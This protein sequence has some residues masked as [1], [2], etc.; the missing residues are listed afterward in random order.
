MIEKIKDIKNNC[1][2][3]YQSSNRIVI[4]G[5]INNC[6]DEYQLQDGITLVALVVTIIVLLILAGIAISLTVG[7]NGLFSRARNAANTWKESEVNELTKMEEFAN[8]YDKTLN[9]LELNGNK[10]EIEEKA[11]TVEYAKSNINSSNIQKYIGREVEYNSPKGG[12]WRVFYYD[13]DGYFG[14]PDTLYLKMD[15]DE[16]NK[17]A[18]TLSTKTGDTEPAV[19]IMKKMNPKWASS[20]Y[21]VI[22]NNN[23]KASVWLCDPEVWIE[24]KANSSSYSIGSPSVEMYM[25]AFNIWKTG[26]K[27][28]NNLINKIENAKGYSVGSNGEYENSGYWTKDNT[29]ES[30]PSNIFM[31]VGNHFW[32]LA[33]PSSDHSGDVLFISGYNAY[34]NGYSYINT[35]GICP[36]VPLDQ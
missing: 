11:I 33:S 30:G 32:W 8:I 14:R 7:N 3:D 19:Q 13:E 31:K 10:G 28:S 22:D 12:I 17:T 6:R 16:K 5:R 25:K 15:Y 26:N 27:D 35:Y 23:E 29:I 24:Y 9:D 18:L 20:S 2:E 36:I 4:K 34:V 1:R 21:S